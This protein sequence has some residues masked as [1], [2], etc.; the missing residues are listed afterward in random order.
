MRVDRAQFVI[1]VGRTNSILR[2][3]ND[4]SGAFQIQSPNDFKMRLVEEA[5]AEQ[6]PGALFDLHFLPLP[7]AECTARERKLIA[8]F[9]PVVNSLPKPNSQERSAIERAYRAY[10]RAAIARQA[11]DDT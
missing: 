3:V 10:Y 7:E 1:Y 2:R 11:T 6:Y 4:Y 9:Q 5:L 8:Q